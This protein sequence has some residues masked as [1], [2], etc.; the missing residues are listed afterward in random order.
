[1][2]H[3]LIKESITDYIKPVPQASREPDAGV[4]MHDDTREITE[5]I[6]SAGEK[7]RRETSDEPDPVITRTV[8]WPLTCTVGPG[9]EG[10]IACE[11][12]I[13]YV[14]G[15]KGWLIYRGYDIFDL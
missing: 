9:L 15:A 2:I 10:A 6:L 14:N 11:S 7:A 4:N 3:L 5:I 8:E 1:M 12:R 13:G